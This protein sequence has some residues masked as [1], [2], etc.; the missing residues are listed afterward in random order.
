MWKHRLDE[1]EYMSLP[2]HEQ[3][4]RRTRLLAVVMYVVFGAMAVSLWYL[5]SRAVG[6]TGGAGLLFGITGAVVGAGILAFAQ[7]R[8]D[9]R[10]ER[11]E[12]GSGRLGTWLIIIAGGSAAFLIKLV[13]DLPQTWRVFSWAF[14]A[15]VITASFVFF[16]RARRRI[17]SDPRLF[18]RAREGGLMT[19]PPE[20]PH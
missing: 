10:R 4:M 11:G 20:P 16:A 6:G 7:L 9:R 12:R 8:T 18:L 3:F 5:V 19:R 13:Q 2:E 17:A 15:G 14:V 1:H